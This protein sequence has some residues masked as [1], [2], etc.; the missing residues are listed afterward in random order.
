MFCLSTELPLRCD[1]P[2][3]YTTI[4]AATAGHTTHTTIESD[5]GH[6]T[7]QQLSQMML[8]LLLISS[9][10][11]PTIEAAVESDEACTHSN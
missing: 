3:G 11:H 5:D 10:G 9:D 2:A 6:T 8:T 1:I 4:E 7:P